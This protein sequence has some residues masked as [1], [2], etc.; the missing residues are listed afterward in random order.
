M[1]QALSPPEE[2]ARNNGERERLEARLDDVVELRLAR[3]APAGGPGGTESM[4]RLAE[5]QASLAAYQIALCYHIGT[6]AVVAWAVIAERLRTYTLPV[7]V[8]RLAELVDEVT[9]PYREGDPSAGGQP[10]VIGQ[11]AAVLL[12]PWYQEQAGPAA[13]HLIVVPDGRLAYLP[14]EMLPLPDGRLLADQLTVSYAPSLST[15]SWLHARPAATA[16]SVFVAFADPV[17]SQPP[18]A[19]AEGSVGEGPAGEEHARPAVTAARADNPVALLLPVGHQLSPLP[20]TRAEAQAIARL[21]GADGA[22]FV[23]PDNTA[24]RVRD[25]APRYRIQHWAT[26]SLLDEVDPDFSGLVVSPS[27][28]QAPDSEAADDLVTVYDL[29]RLS[30]QADLVVCS[31]C[32]TGLGTVRAGEGT[33]G[34]S[35][36]LLSAGARC[37]VLSLW[38]VPDRPTRRLM[39]AF[40]QALRRGEPPADALRTAKA[41]VRR[42]YPRIYQYPFTWA[43]FVVIGDATSHVQLTSPIPPT[44]SAR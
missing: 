25:A 34:M 36:A 44:G 38:P 40:Y 28:G 2:A 16:P 27:A 15:L 26:H 41:E 5:L 24:R 11:L 31:A 23:G 22:A 17:I 13:S 33:I 21:F 20:G 19:G 42:R 1:P 14:F 43:A 3:A 32:Q 9:L 6:D 4:P 35:K 8:D 12:A 18:V 30:L 39:L 7:G 10:A 37:V 29:A